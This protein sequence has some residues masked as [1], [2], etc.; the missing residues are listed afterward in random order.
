MYLDVCL[1]CLG[2]NSADWNREQHRQAQ[3]WKHEDL[4]FL[5]ASDYPHPGVVHEALGYGISVQ[6]LCGY[7][8]VFDVSNKPLL[9]WTWFL[10]CETLQPCLLHPTGSSGKKTRTMPAL[11]HR[12]LSMGLGLLVCTHLDYLYKSHQRS[13]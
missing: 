4:C 5:T 11:Y 3:E 9:C 7:P 8:W 13:R 12:K 2:S 10:A 1:L 6:S